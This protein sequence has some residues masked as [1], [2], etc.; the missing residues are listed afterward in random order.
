MNISRLPGFWKGSTLD[1]RAVLVLLLAFNSL[2]LA[3]GGP[4]ISENA[5]C[6]KGNVAK[7]GE[8]DGPAELPKS[9]YYTG[10]D[11]TPSPGKQIRVK[12]NDDLYEELDRAKC[13][14]TLLLPAGASFLVKELPKKGCDDQHYITI[15]TGTPDSK[16]PPEGTR[17]SPAWAGVAN[18]PGRPPYAQPAGGPA[19]LMA[20]ILVKAVATT[21]IG[22]HYRFIGIEWTTAP[23]AK[24]TRMVTTDGANHVIFDRNWF[25]P[26]DG[27]EVSK[28]VLMNG[29]TH[30]IAVLNSYFSGFNC[31]ARSGACTDA[32]AVAGGHGHGS[33]TITTLK[34]YNNYLEASGQSILFGGASSDINPVDIEIRRNH[35]FKPMIWKEGEPGYTPAPSG[36]PYIVKNNLELKSG[37]RVLIEGNLLEN[38]W[39]GF[40]QKGF[41][42]LFTPKNQND[43]CPKCVVLDVTLRYNR[44][45]NVAAGLQIATG[46]SKKGGASA[47]GGRISIHDLIVDSVHNTG[48]V[49]NGP[50]A[51]IGTHDPLLH[52]IAFDHVTAFATGPI[53]AITT[54]G[55]KIINFSV[56]NSIFTSG[57]DRP[58]LAAAGGGK[59][60]CASRTQRVG[61]HAV[62]DACFTNYRFE[63]NLVV[64]ERG[65]GGWPPGT[66]VVSSLE[67]AGL[68][69]LENGI[70]KN[71]RLCRAQ[72]AGCR[73][74]SPGV[75]AGTD[76]KDIGADVDAV[77][78]AVSGVE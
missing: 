37:R 32:S 48:W 69:E 30:F 51:N 21:T 57:G 27:V 49:G 19:K 42:V 5:Y 61:A 38:S 46:L 12:A 1:L 22:D 43:N 23:G 41:S 75:G 70:S 78:A 58:Q 72:E 10:L 54:R 60:N 66:I 28:G 16:L 68:R 39:G 35:L 64:A 20:T 33:E 52:D 24:A 4:P 6:G 17:I 3:S 47:D 73:K 59:I 62:L 67:A 9:C 50:F 34:I 63:K 11:G 76:G 18:L 53:F 71:P 13:G 29:D 40:T 15:R 26:A 25:H 77:D 45:R 31:V 14:D 56:T 8:K 44:I 65:R 55:E 36:D 2:A 7:F 74:P